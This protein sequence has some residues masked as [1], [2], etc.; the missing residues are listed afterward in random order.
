MTAVTQGVTIW[1][2]IGLQYFYFTIHYAL[3]M[4]QNISPIAHYMN[5][6]IS[7][8]SILGNTSV[9]TCSRPLKQQRLTLYMYMGELLLVGS[10]T[11]HLITIKHSCSKG[12]MRM[13][14]L[15]YTHVCS[16]FFQHQI[17]NIQCNR[18]RHAQIT[19]CTNIDLYQGNWEALLYI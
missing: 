3:Y 12:W 4:Y 1:E 8:N 16:P 5:Y 6:F 9:H 11:V 14:D 18:H 2:K 10:L 7:C 15:Y 19:F 17:T 13:T